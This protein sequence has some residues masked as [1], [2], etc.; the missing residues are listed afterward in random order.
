[1]PA[2]YEAQYLMSQNGKSFLCCL[3][4]IAGSTPIQLFEVDIDTA[5]ATGSRM[6]LG[7]HRCGRLHWRKRT[8]GC[9]VSPR[10]VSDAC[11]AS[12]EA[13]PRTREM[14]RFRPILVPLFASAVG[15]AARASQSVA[16]GF[17]ALNARDSALQP[18]ASWGE[19]AP[20]SGTVATLRR[21]ME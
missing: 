16:H 17:V 18:C 4:R 19:P 6:A 9:M 21:R 5:E 10:I 15:S 1:V 3:R 20:R 13:D 12:S 2:G 7:G 8:R 11:R 14:A